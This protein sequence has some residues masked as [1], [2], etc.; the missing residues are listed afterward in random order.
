MCRKGQ[1]YD[2]VVVKVWY[3]LF[4]K[5]MSGRGEMRDERIN[6]EKKCIVFFKNKLIFYFK[7]LFQDDFDIK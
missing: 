6:Y 1:W 7:K 2:L 3:V 5:D 4:G